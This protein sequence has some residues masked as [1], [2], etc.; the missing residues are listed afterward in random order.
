MSESEPGEKEKKAKPALVRLGQNGNA[1]KPSLSG[2][3]TPRSGGLA[4][5]LG[6]L[7]SKTSPF[8][9]PK[10][11]FS[12]L[13]SP[14]SSPVHTF[15]AQRDLSLGAKPVLG[16]KSG[17]DTKPALG[18]LS[19]KSVVNSQT[20]LPDRKKF[21]PNLNV[22]RQ[23]KKESDE[24]E[25]NEPK[26]KRRKEN[27]HE[28]REKNN[29]DRPTLI[30]TGS[31]F[32]EGVAGDGGIRRRIGGSSSRGD[33]EES[34]LVRPKLNLNQ[35]LDRDEE[36]RKLKSLLRD[37]FIDDL[38]E[39]NFV[40]V[41]L[42]MINTGKIFKAEVKKKDGEEDDIRPKLLNKKNNE[43][44]SDDEDDPEPANSIPVI[45]EPDLPTAPGEPSVAELVTHQT[46]Q[47]VFIQLPDSLPLIPDKPGGD[48]TEA[49][50]GSNLNI[51]SLGS[52][53]GRLGTLQVRKSGRC[54]LILG[55]QKFDV[56]TGTKVGF[57]QNAVSI[58][59]PSNPGESGECTVLGHISHRLVMSPDWDTLLH[60]SGLNST[61]A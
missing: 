21:I 51:S 11:N 31:I 46:G 44:D 3:G 48:E 29:R 6:G 22:Q 39:G 2:L 7:A 27:K 8:G 10:S 17:F 30:Q 4:G 56:E 19:P 49:G 35:P 40:P 13:G 28:R 50:A 47:L 23:V 45:S 9:T 24:P 60:Q 1:R 32:S 26:W 37:D 58:R 15:R 18:A 54:Q 42:P 5:P 43:L 59:V 41:Q 14:R 36:E 16:T 12:P 55:K 52:L 33:L 53:E 38:K 61:L 34:G 20:K 57:L 25:K